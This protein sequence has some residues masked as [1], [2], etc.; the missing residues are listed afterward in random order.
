MMARRLP[1]LQKI[2]TAVY[3][4]GVSFYYKL[5]TLLFAFWIYHYNLS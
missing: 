4:H 3:V 1:V 5:F 2:A